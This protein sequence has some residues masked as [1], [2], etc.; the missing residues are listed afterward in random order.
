MNQKLKRFKSKAMFTIIGGVIV[1]NPAF[2]Q[3]TQAQQAP[4][5]AL[6]TE[7]AEQTEQAQP[8]PTPADATTLDTVVVTGTRVA[9][10]VFDVPASVD[11]ID[12]AA[13]RDGRA[14]VN[15]SESVAGVPAP[16]LR[17]ASRILSPSSTR[18]SPRCALRVSRCVV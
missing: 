14:Q 5:P 11:R 15:L 4:P 10:P 17:A 16:T 6:Q 9:D 18:N 8:S 2:A 7:Q 12:A 1:I 3:D 13:I